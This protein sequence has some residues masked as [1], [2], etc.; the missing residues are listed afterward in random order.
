MM[1]FWLS[2]VVVI[3]AVFALAYFDAWRLVGLPAGTSLA[4]AAIP[5]LV[6]AA[7]FLVAAYIGRKT[8]RGLPMQLA[9]SSVAAAGLVAYARHVLIGAGEPDEASHMHVIFFPLALALFAALVMATSAMIARS[10]PR[11][12]AREP[13]R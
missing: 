10:R 3:S 7:S 6:I 11:P 1:K 8:G 13:E 5:A 12:S 4:I 2:V 9:A